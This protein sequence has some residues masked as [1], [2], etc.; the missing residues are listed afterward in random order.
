MSGDP[1]FVKRHVVVTQE[2]IDKGKR[3]DGVR[4]PIALALDPIDGIS[5]DTEEIC[6]HGM[7]Y[8]GTD[9]KLP[10]EAVEFISAFDEGEPVQPFEFDIDWPIW[11]EPGSYVGPSV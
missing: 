3:C 7:G 5:V 8:S 11:D 4:C 9:P 6:L 1:T 10:A 2:H